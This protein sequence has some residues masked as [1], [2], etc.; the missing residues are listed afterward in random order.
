MIQPTFSH[1]GRPYQRGAWIDL[2]VGDGVLGVVGSAPL[3]TSDAHLALQAEPGPSPPHSKAE[4][5]GY[6]LAG[7]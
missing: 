3:P 6:E 7:I 4:A 5:Q 1:H 2:L